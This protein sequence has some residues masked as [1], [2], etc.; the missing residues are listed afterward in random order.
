MD[1]RAARRRP[2]SSGVMPV[3]SNQRRLKY[4]A[5]PS[6]VR[7]PDD[8]RHR[9]GELPVAL[10]ARALERGE[11]LLVQQLCLLLELLR[12]L[13]TARRRPRPSSAGC[14]GRTA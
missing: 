13:A 9:V 4:V 5:P 12:L 7:R 14:R 3:Y 2:G 1:D 10:L 11:L 8:L 6:D